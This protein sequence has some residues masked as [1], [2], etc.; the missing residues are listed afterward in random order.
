LLEEISCYNKNELY[1]VLCF[2]PAEGLTNSYKCVQ[3]KEELD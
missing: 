2:S 1:M 3:M